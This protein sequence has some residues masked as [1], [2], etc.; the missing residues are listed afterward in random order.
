MK[1]TVSLKLNRDFRRMYAKGRRVVG[2]YVVVYALK[3]KQE[4]N[5]LGLTVGRQVGKACR[6]NRIKRLIREAVRAEIHKIKPGY[7]IVI[8]ARNRALGRNYQE[9]AADVRYGLRKL[10]LYNEESCN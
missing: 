10:S 2:G 9:I 4:L 1:D 5:R 8:V 6:R 7:D 3:N